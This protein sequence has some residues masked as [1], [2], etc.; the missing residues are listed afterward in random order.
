[1]RHL[2]TS[3]F[4][5]L[6]LA[7]APFAA[8]V[9]AAPQSPSYAEPVNPNA[10]PEA[11]SLLK[12][13]DDISGHYTLTG[14]H[15]FP[16][17]LSRWSDRIYDLT[18]KFPAI[19]GQDFGFA[20]G[21]DKDSVLG[22]PSMIEEVTRQYRNGAVIALTWH[23]VR[24]TDDE[25]VTFRDSVQGHLTDFEWNELLTPGTDLYNR[26]AEQVD[27]I[28]GYLG[29]LQAAGVP[30]LFRAYHEMNGNW[31]WW[32]GRPGEHGSAAL[33]RQIYNRF[34]N[35]HHLNNLIWVWNVNSPGGNA[36]P[37]DSYYPG[38]QYADIVT[39]DIYGEFKQSYYDQMLALAG[40]KPIALAEVGAMPTLDVLAKQPRWAYFMMWSG[41][42]EF[43]NTPEQ[44]QTMFHAPNLLNRG[45]PP[46]VP[47]PAPA[48]VNVVPV[49]PDALPAVKETLD[50]LY[51]DE[52]THVLSGQQNTA[53]SLAGAIQRVFQT[54]AKYPVIY[55]ADLD[56]SGGAD[57]AKA[58]VD[59]SLK[60]SRDK[61]IVSLRWL[62]PNPAET[63]TASVDSQGHDSRQRALTGFEWQELTTPGTD[64]NKNWAAQVDEAAAVLKKLDEKGVAVMWTPYP[65]SNGKQY[66]WA[67]HSG[68][69]GSAALYRM[70][71][72]R[73]VN[74]DHLRNLV[75][76]WE[77]A[78]PGFGP[79]AT[80]MYSDYF[81]GLL[82]ADALALH[83][84]RTESRFR[85][86]AFLSA[87]AVGKAIGVVI[88]GTPPDP[89]FFAKETGWSWFLLAPP[90]TATTANTAG[91]DNAPSEALRTLY[92]DPRIISR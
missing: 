79:D 7:S 82:Y 29:Q 54:T 63:G 75:W 50:R 43:A 90:A 66:W 5:F 73:L 4:L 80:G 88:D 65:E 68:I 78:L 41:L 85:S 31:F 81:P 74:Q 22:R 19:F 32:G 25:P 84:S 70:L 39:M 53:A 23:A 8:T 71:F 64:L 3:V 33:Y 77:A 34:V 55:G 14:Q 76:V 49:T 89:A 36:G 72:D 48:S 86:D 51:A 57:S 40:N 52:G 62:A 10:T 11:R 17:D 26:W 91:A 1:M 45:D 9:Q 83:V 18:G 67:G 27:V 47:T 69:H 30:V 6:L 16:N 61:S 92:A 59:E 37:I 21:Q 56:S 13:L 46:F 20:G 87:S 2:K 24:P 42:A 60:Q 35:V 15:N 28:A 12:K 38:P 44:L 58:V